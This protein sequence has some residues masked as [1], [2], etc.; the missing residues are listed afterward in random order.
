VPPARPLAALLA[1][2]L[3]ATGCTGGG[4]GDGVDPSAAQWEQVA[5]PPEA[6][7]RDLGV[8]YAAVLP[9]TDTRPAVVVGV[10]RVRSEPPQAVAWTVEGADD[11]R[12][13]RILVPSRYDLPVEG[14]GAEEV[15]T[16]FVGPDGRAWAA[17]TTWTSADGVRAWAAVSADGAAWEAVPVEG[18]AGFVPVTGVAAGT[19]VLLLGSDGERRPAVVGLAGAEPGALPDPPAEQFRGFEQAAAL[20]DALVALGTAGEPGEPDVVVAYRSADGGRTWQVG[21][22]PAAEFVTGVTAVPTGFVAAG[23]VRPAPGARSEPRAWSSADGASWQEERLPDDALTRLGD[24]VDR[25]L[26]RP[27]AGGDRVLAAVTA[28][29]ELSTLRVERS[30]DGTW[31]PG[32]ELDF[33]VPGVGPLVA[34]AAD[35][36]VLQVASSRGGGRIAL[37]EPTATGRGIVSDDFGRPDLGLTWQHFL[38]AESPVLVA[39]RVVLELTGGGGWTQTTPVSRWAV[40]G[41]ALVA[42]PADPPESEG[43]D[44]LSSARAD[45]DAEVLLGSRLVGEDDQREQVLGWHRPGPDAPWTPV[46]GFDS[47]VSDRLG[48]VA[49]AGEGWVAVGETRE[50]F[51]ASARGSGVAWTSADG[52]AWQRAELPGAVP[53]SF[54]AGACA[55]PDGTPLVVGGVPEGEGYRPA[56]WRAGDSGFVELPRDA[57]PGRGWATGCAA[58]EGETVVQGQRDG[59]PAAW[60]T[61]DGE[62]WEARALG[63]RGDSFGRIRAVEGGFAAAGSRASGTARGAVVWLSRDGSRWTPVAVPARRVL[64]GADVVQAEGAL[65][66]A[67]NSASSPE[68]WR[69]A[70]ARELLSPR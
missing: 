44:T 66:V 36:T 45:D 34:P 2:A 6:E 27:A 12:G 7:Q 47:P 41:G 31:R 59:L 40:E 69:L 20:G 33:V 39:Q 53:D 8:A 63:E 50:S 48:D 13:D 70:N 11:R 21:D 35:G 49:R 14:E 38:D 10:D 46:T 4:D 32:T 68:L 56:A 58:G 28:E 16:G 18:P 25:W 52:L 54:V 22:G 43:V 24:D 26:A 5:L 37:D 17:G 64:S 55:L 65:L 57:L 29:D 3:L 42:A 30:A 9:R 15:L 62:D 19:G 60:T 51:E 67:A 61:A 1:A 23:A